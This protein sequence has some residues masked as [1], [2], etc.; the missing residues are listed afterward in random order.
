[1]SQ[2]V[3]QLCFGLANTCVDFIRKT[4]KSQSTFDSKRKVSVRPEKSLLKK[5]P[6]VTSQDALNKM[7]R[8]GGLNIKK[9]SVKLTRLRDGDFEQNFS[10]MEQQMEPEPKKTKALPKKTAKKPLKKPKAYVESD[11]DEDFQLDSG[12]SDSDQGPSTSSSNRKRKSAMSSDETSQSSSK[13]LRT[14]EVIV[15]AP[16]K[17]SCGKCKNY[18]PDLGALMG[19]V[20]DKNCVSVGFPCETCGKVYDC[21][22]KLNNHVTQVHTEKYIVFC[23]QCG[24][25]LKDAFALEAH[26]EST[27]RRIVRTDCVFRCSKC[28]ETFNSHL[29]LMNHVKIHKNSPTMPCPECGREILK[30]SWYGHVQWH[31]H[32]KNHSCDVRKLSF[33]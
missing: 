32:E 4:K 25:E 13:T 14:S 5:T 6:T 28:S 2:H 15:A 16:A 20:K 1:M 27:H 19:H 30:N 22:S 18:F 31:K 17:Y 10:W 11:S 24:K 3:C 12:S 8:I 9:V 7:E 26:I 23:D 21:K 29:D 33:S